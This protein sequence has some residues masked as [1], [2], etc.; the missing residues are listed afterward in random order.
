MEAD[1]C[2]KGEEEGSLSGNEARDITWD[3]KPL[4]LMTPLRN[5]LT[6]NVTQETLGS[7]DTLDKAD[8]ASTF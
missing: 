3:S 1:H 8:F 4:Q 5:I 6:K 2:D 7:M